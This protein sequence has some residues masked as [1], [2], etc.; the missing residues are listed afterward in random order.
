[1]NALP[2]ATTTLLLI[3]VTIAG[4][5]DIRSRRI[6]NWLT[7]SGVVLGLALNGF[8]YGWPGVWFALKGLGL[9]LLV[10]LPF[11]ALRGMGAGDVKLMAAVGALIGP[12]NWLWVFILTGL[13]GG[14]IG[15]ALAFSRGRA[16]TT[17]A[18][19]GFILKELSRFR[20]PHVQREDLDV[21]NPDAL[22]LPH[23]AVIA[24][25]VI[26]FVSAAKIWGVW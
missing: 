22:R 16:L 23:G 12:W 1:M 25:G 15:L 10:Y 11:F 19:V 24:L 2:P 14:V 21:A 13:L 8:L 6:P 20:A 17:L 9:A 26:G 7:V 5:I 18:N 3:L 4:G